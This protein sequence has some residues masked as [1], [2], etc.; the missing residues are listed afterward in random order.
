MNSL[1]NF[2][3]SSR[4]R[5]SSAGRSSRAIMDA[6]PGIRIGDRQRCVDVNVE[7]GDVDNDVI[8]GGGLPESPDPVTGR[9]SM[10]E[11]AMMPFLLGERPNRTSSKLDLILKFCSSRDPFDGDADED[12]CCSI[13]KF[14]SCCCRFCCCCCNATCNV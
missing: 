9:D 14:F 10:F 4:S 11:T 8:G 5:F 2:S 6:G 7:N 12:V 13:R 1:A 3:S